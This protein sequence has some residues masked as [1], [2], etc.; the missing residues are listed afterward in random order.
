MRKSIHEAITSHYR[1]LIKENKDVEKGC[2][3][4]CGKKMWKAI[5][6]ALDKDSGSAEISSL[7]VQD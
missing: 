4:E 3:K 7:D 6:E 5:N 1:G 2:R